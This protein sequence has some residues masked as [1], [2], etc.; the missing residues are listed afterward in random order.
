MK[1]SYLIGA[2]KN[3]IEEIK[4]KSQEIK[5]ENFTIK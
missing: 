4:K 1:D 2:Q 5:I 3:L